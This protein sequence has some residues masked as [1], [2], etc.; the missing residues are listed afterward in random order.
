MPEIPIF[1]VHTHAFPDK[2][3]ATAI[4]RLEAAGVWFRPQASF[5]GTVPG[6]LASM[7]R[8]G[9]RRSIICSVVT[10]PEQTPKITDWSASIASERIVPFASI[11]PDYPEVE[12][13]IERV[14]QLGLK[15]LKYHP[16][17]GGYPLDDPKV[18]RIARAAAAAG[19]AMLFH[20]GHDLAF[21]KDDSATP[22][23]VR[24]LHEAAPDLRMTAAH[25]GGWE[26]WPDVL[27]QVAGL[28]IYLETSF[29]LGRCPADVL[30]RIFAKHP[31][32]YL[33][34]GTDAPWRDQQEEVEKFMA[35]P[36]GDGVKRRILWDNALRFAG[37]SG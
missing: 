23:R 28:P 5:D 9:I 7:D 19:L 33:L 13:E 36:L 24:R 4:P 35:L 17:Y 20:T 26:L 8:A 30:E 18:V 34:F 3:A 22:S 10:R 16:H 11:H 31:P 29:T 14:A 1:D 2:L 12:A 25:L 37:M 6:L 32:E 15:G 27:E 21:E